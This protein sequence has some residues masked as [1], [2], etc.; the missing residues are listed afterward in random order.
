LGVAVV[1]AETAAVSAVVAEVAAVAAATAVVVWLLAR[2][3]GLGVDQVV[4]W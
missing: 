4:W 3:T 1:A 2:R